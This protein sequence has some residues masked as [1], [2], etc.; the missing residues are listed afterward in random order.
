MATQ[1]KKSSK[2]TAC[3]V[4]AFKKQYPTVV[5]YQS[6]IRSDCHHVGGNMVDLL[7]LFSVSTPII[8][9]ANKVWKEEAFAKHPV[10]DSSSVC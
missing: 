2:E 3:L 10:A 7:L 9:G 6:K 1:M 5:E 4:N 8:R